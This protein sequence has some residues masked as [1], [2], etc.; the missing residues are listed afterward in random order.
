ML[1][2]EVGAQKQAN[3]WYF[4]GG[5]G[6]T[7]NTDPPTA[8]TGGQ[9]YYPTPAL[10]NEGT[11]SICDSAGALLYYS[12]GAQV[13]DRTHEVMPNG[14]DLMGHPSSTQAA[15]IIA[16]PG[17][18]RYF[19]IFTTDGSEHG[20]DNGLRHSV[21]DACLRNGLGDV[22]PDQ[23]NMLLHGDMA[24]K[25]AAVQHANGQDYWIVGHE[26]GTNIFHLYLLTESGITDSLSI[27]IGPSEITGWGGQI[28]LSPD[29]T[30]LAYASATL[31]GFLA[32]FDLNTS[33]GLLSNERVWMSSMSRMPW[34]LAFSPNGSKLY[35][36]TTNQGSIRQL[37]LSA[38]DWPDVQASEITLG[39]I[40][41]DLWR[42]LRLGPD[43]SI[44]VA[45]AQHPSLGI[46]AFPD[47][48]G[49]ACQFQ[50]D[51]LSLTAD[52]SFGLPNVV[53][54][55]AYHNDVHPCA[56]PAGIEEPMMRITLGPNPATDRVDLRC[57]GCL[58][59]DLV[60][61]DVLGRQ[62][63]RNEGRTTSSLTLDVGPWSAGCYLVTVSGGGHRLFQ[64]RLIKQ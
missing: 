51:A 9:T 47:A 31:Q 53:C 22:L 36:T 57:E 7:F 63:H 1:V 55:Y 54:G 40:M 48:P 21:I 39:T 2:L 64:G 60:V 58:F 38:G 34:G 24:E 44:Y 33:T 42:D 26:F 62:V 10:W 25:L 13:W 12:N 19:H 59:G 56:E 6:L 28:V 3:V 46:I 27:G 23:K 8:I 32:L 20:F 14:A 5:A 17:S 30:T 29:G 49:P 37:D 43:G 41:P 4:G 16:R 45:H 11:S 52:C 15:L 61:C 50:D 35:F 18:D